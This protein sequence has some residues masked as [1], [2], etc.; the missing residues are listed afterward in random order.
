MPLNTNDSTSDS[1][2]N[3]N[4]EPNTSPF[5]DDTPQNANDFDA[6][7]DAEPNMSLENEYSQQNRLVRNL[8]ASL[9]LSQSLTQD[10]PSNANVAST[11]VVSFV[12]SAAKTSSLL[13]IQST[14]LS[15]SANSVAGLSRRR[16]M[17]ISSSS[18]I[19]DIRRFSCS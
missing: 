10:L 18:H 5:C 8:A 13:S 12:A 14:L 16:S 11:S 1:D 15:P 9:E 17:E 4:A 2:D 6:D 3:W 7:W 19:N